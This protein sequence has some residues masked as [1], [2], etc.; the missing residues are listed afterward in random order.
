[1]LFRIRGRLCT[2]ED[3]VVAVR[4]L[5]VLLDLLLQRRQPVLHQVDVLENSPVALC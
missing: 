1:M 4:A 3:P 2:E 5:T